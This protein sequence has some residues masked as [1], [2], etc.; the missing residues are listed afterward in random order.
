MGFSAPYL[1]WVLLAFSLLLGH[2]IHSDALGI[3]V[4]HL[5]FF[6][7]DVWPA[8]ARARGWKITKILPTPSTISALITHLRTPVNNIAVVRIP[9]VPQGVEGPQGQ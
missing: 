5:Y 8:L 3:A 2:D 7:E 9:E 4:G 6:F 1:P